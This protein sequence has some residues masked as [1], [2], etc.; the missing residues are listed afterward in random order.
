MKNLRIVF[1]LVAICATLFTSC[2]KDDENTSSPGYFIVDGKKYELGKAYFEYNEIRDDVYSSSQFIQHAVYFVSEDITIK[3]RDEGSGKGGIVILQFMDPLKLQIPAPG[4]YYYQMDSKPVKP[5]TYFDFSLGY[6]DFENSSVDF[7]YQISDATVNEAK[8][9]DIY[10]F[11][12]K[13]TT[14]EGKAFEFYYKGT[15]ALMPEN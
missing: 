7:F 9:G 4:V 1:V 15:I 5:Y 8:S 13:G 3:N 11:S 6:G 2:E 10:E 14:D 12:S